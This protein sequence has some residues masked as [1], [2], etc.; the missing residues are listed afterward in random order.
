MDGKID[1]NDIVTSKRIA[2]SNP[3]YASC[4]R[5]KKLALLTGWSLMTHFVPKE[6]KRFILDKSV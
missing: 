6:L 2:Y 4:A 1:W 3:S 5:A